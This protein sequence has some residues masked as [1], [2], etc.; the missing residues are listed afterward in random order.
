MSKKQPINLDIKMDWDLSDTF[1]SKMLASLTSKRYPKF[2][3]NINFYKKNYDKFDT[4]DECIKFL[5]AYYIQKYTINKLSNYVSKTDYVNYKYSNLNYFIDYKLIDLSNSA[6]GRGYGGHDPLD[7]CKL[8]STKF[9]IEN[10]YDRIISDKRFLDEIYNMDNNF[11][12]GAS[13]FYGDSKYAY[14][15]REID[16]GSKQIA[17]I[18]VPTLM[19]L[20]KEYEIEKKHLSTLNYSDTKLFDIYFDALNTYTQELDKSIKKQQILKQIGSSKVKQYIESFNIGFQKLH[21]LSNETMVVYCQI[22]EELEDTQQKEHE[23]FDKYSLTNDPTHR[24][25]LYRYDIGIGLWFYSHGYIVIYTLSHVITFMNNPFDFNM[26]NNEAFLEPFLNQTQHKNFPQLQK[27][28][29]DCRG[30]TFIPV[31]TIYVVK[32]FNKIKKSMF[33]QNSFIT[34]KIEN[35]ID[36]KSNSACG[37]GHDPLQEIIRDEIKENNKKKRK[38]KKKSKKINTIIDIELI[39]NNDIIE[40]ENTIDITDDTDKSN[41]SDDE[42]EIEH[43]L[44]KIIQENIIEN[45]ENN[46][47]IVSKKTHFNISFNYYNTFESKSYIRFLINDCYKN[48]EKFNLFMSNYT[49]VRV[50]R[51]IHTD[52][53]NLLKSLHFNLVFFNR[54]FNEMTPTYHAYIYN[55]EISSMTRLECIF[56]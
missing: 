55:N 49:D 9:L 35:I 48:N 56:N 13:V 22:I 47:T 38:I 34:Q 41:S 1:I 27:C 40:I 3:E 31:Y 39:N 24:N 54:D 11:Y 52:Q 33:N 7:E 15:Y 20:K 26:T 4:Y 2:E 25:N 30:K 43:E 17:N 42:I 8:I 46:Y 21:N 14:S 12:V 37:R 6:C 50:K 36:N 29:E 51:D 23:L 19:S 32:N 28:Y 16:G 10:F 53:N 44:Q 18:I 45:E 5:D